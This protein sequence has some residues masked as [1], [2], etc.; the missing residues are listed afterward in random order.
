MFERLAS[1]LLSR[2]LSKYF[3]SNDS[4]SNGAPTLRHP[5]PRR[6]RRHGPTWEFGVDTCHWKVLNYAKRL[7]IAI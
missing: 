6:R 3:V 1:K 7:S 2:L 5:P 4:V